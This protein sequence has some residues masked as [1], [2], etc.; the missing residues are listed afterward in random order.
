MERGKRHFFRCIMGG[1]VGLMLATPWAMPA[2]ARGHDGYPSKPV[3]LLVGFP[4]GSSTDVA[5]RVLAQKLGSILGEPF[6]VINQPGASSNIAARAVAAAAPDGL[7]LFVGTIANAI[8]ITLQPGVSVD[9]L[10]NLMPVAAIGSM[11]NILVANPALGV[12][13]LQQ[14]IAKARSEPGRITFASSGIGTSPH[15]SGELFAAM[16][17]TKL[18][19]V[20]YK[21]S[22][23]AVAD[24]L[25]GQVMI[26]FSPASSVLPFVHAG[27]LKA[28]ASAS[29]TRTE[30][31]PNLPTLNELGLK[32][33]D[34]SV[35]FGL[36]APLGTPPA[37]I[38]RLSAA[39]RRAQSD[40]DL[41]R[42]FKQQA[43]DIV[44]GGPQQY[45][46]LIRAETVKWARVIH[47]AQVQV[48]K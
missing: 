32:G 34:S 12:D 29:L 27:K 43:I 9:L 4:A 44:R 21:G 5:T 15:L 11:P 42:Q 2:S 33:F 40:P 7:T 6:V 10:K 14:L 3:R 8:S 36:N 30:A 35:W 31:A 22:S 17:H 41:Q 28:L 16:T 45:A 46:K 18:L 23:L 24:L 13:T 26:M 19:H 1:C 48:S 47:A 37:I 25:S 20:P 38:E 39:V